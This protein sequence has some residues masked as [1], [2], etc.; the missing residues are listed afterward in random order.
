VAEV[1]EVHRRDDGV[2]VCE[3]ALG[4]EVL[5]EAGAHEVEGAQ[6]VDLAGRQLALAVD[7]A[8]VDL[9]AVLVFRQLADAVV[10]LEEGA[11]DDQPLARGLDEFFEIVVGRAGVQELCHR[12]LS[13]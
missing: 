12:C 4:V 13:L 8:H 3:S 1:V 2:A 11:D 6:P 7:D 10:E 9:H 5:A